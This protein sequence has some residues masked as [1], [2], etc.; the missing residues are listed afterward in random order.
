MHDE[1]LDSN[2]RRLLGRYQDISDLLA[3][4]RIWPPVVGRERFVNA[5]RATL[6]RLPQSVFDVVTEQA[7]FVLQVPGMLATCVA[8]LARRP[9]Y[10][11]IFFKEWMDLSHE[12]LI[13]LIAHELAH[14]I[15]EER[16]Y[17]RDERAADRRVLSWG[18]RSELTA[19][20][21]QKEKGRPNASRTAAKQ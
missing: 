8:P 3:S 13:G 20:R 9:P 6:A 2:G 12:A 15:G 14:V 18:F 10:T 17:E 5:L 21:Q 7:Q 16:T 11:I 4:D 1:D 19:L